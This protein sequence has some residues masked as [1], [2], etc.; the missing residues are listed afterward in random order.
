M[1]KA[2]PRCVEDLSK[3]WAALFLFLFSWEILEAH[4]AQLKEAA[5]Q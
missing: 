4:V 3:V 1:S 5:A 2:C